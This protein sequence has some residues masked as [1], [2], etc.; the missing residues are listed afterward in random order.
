MGK[1]F[2]PMVG[3]LTAKVTLKPRFE[4]DI[5]SNVKQH[6]K[7]DYD[8]KRAGLGHLHFA[9]GTRKDEHKSNLDRQG[10]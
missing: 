4:A 8:I 5:G 9:S 3:R 10:Y 6:L 2:G 1:I 7:D